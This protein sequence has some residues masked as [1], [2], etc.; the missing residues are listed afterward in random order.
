MFVFDIVD[1]FRGESSPAEGSGT[2]TP[3]QL[4]KQTALE[5]GTLPT[6]AAGMCDETSGYCPD[7]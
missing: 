4:V 3:R 6:T 7:V 2:W 5:Q 1:Q